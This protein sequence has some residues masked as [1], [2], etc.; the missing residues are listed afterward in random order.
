MVE[1]TGERPKWV[2]LWSRLGFEA[3]K[4]HLGAYM[5]RWIL[6][7]PFTIRL[8]GGWR[9]SEIR[10]HKIL[11]SDK[12]RHS[13]DHPFDFWSLLLTGGYDEVLPSSLLFDE[14]TA[15]RR[16]LSVVRHRGADA[17][18]LIL[19]RPVW[20]LVLVSPKYREWGFHTED[21][22]VSHDDYENLV[23]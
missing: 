16:W 15:R 14:F 23:K 6:K 12:D 8:P 3:W 21:G 4:Y 17:H 10:L 11:R 19:T 13:H 22:W 7:L 18:R 9:F 1:E 20:T 2:H 5:L